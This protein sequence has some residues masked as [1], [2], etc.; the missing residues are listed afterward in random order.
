MINDTY[1]LITVYVHADKTAMFEK[2]KQLGV[3]G[4]ALNVFSYACDEVK[5][6]LKV[7]L[8]TGYASIV[9]V[10]GNPVVERP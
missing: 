9:E 7:H 6:L 1:T 5:L 8:A 10:N 4:G 2:G 3:S